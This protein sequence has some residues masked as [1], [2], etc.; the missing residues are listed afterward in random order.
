MGCQPFRLYRLTSA[1]RTYRMPHNNT[2]LLLSD[3]V[4]EL[5]SSGTPFTDI[6]IESGMEIMLRQSPYKWVKAEIGGQPVS[7]Q[8]D[9]IINFLNGVFVGEEEKTPK[10]KEGLQWKMNLHERGSLH[11]ALNLTKI[12][13]G[14]AKTYR[15]R[16]TVQ[17]QMMGESIGLVLR[18]LADVPKDI[19]SLGLPFQVEKMLKSASRGMIIVTGPTGSGKSTT[20]AAMISELN[21]SRHGNILTIEDPVEFVHDRKLC[22]I[23]Q[24]EL[25]IDVNTFADGVRDALRFVPDVILIGEIR[26]AETMKAAVRATESG[27]L[28]MA[29]MHAPTAFTAIRKMLAYLSDSKADMQTLA[30]LLLGVVAQA[31][32]R[33]KTG[34]GKNH[35]ASE[36]LDCKDMRVVQAIVDTA[37]GDDQQQKLSTLEKQLVSGELDCGMAMIASLKQLV[38]KDL[39]DG[40][41]AASAVTT[42]EE[43]SQ[44]L[45]IVAQARV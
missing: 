25:G 9:Q 36:F 27:H 13:D 33:D 26:D 17:K 1:Q 6:H 41:S 4:V 38:N 29:S 18:P 32:V 8:H 37:S 3:I 40:A 24:R 21:A 2:P 30:Y 28:V 35:L 45:K 22:I 11:P 12:S 44:L 19:A 16:C 42:N 10:K 20:L 7:V 23:N 15:V 43:K 5:L 39:V 14:V 31:L 34:N